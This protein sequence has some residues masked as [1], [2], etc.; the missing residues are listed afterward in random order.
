MKY[1]YTA[2]EKE[3]NVLENEL[4]QKRNQIELSMVEQDN[5]TTHIDRLE[6]EIKNLRISENEVKNKLQKKEEE[7]LRKI[8]H[9]E[10]DLKKERARYR[11][12]RESLQ[13]QLNETSK[14]HTMNFTQHED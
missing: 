6:S 8:T 3:K 11:D 2:I 1:R 9:L 12:E 4:I 10:E 14:L 13:E 5:L 7:L